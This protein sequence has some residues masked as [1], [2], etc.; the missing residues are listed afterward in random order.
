MGLAQS[1]LVKFTPLKKIKLADGDVMHGLKSEDDGYNGFGEAY[2]SWINFSAVKAWKK[3][4]KMNMN[5]IVPV[6][7]VLFVFLDET[8]KIFCEEKIGSDRYGRLTVPR[9][10]W[11]G[12]KGL[13]NPSSL[14][15]N[16]ADI[17]HDPA[18]VERA[19]FSSFNY[20]WGI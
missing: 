13:S 17:S 16:I 15:L 18:E 4:R 9:N 14:L 7:H 6:G 19:D 10:T 3:H 12:F 20:D 5:L 11:F 1:G 2:F 8:K